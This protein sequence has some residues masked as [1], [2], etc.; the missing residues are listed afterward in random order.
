MTTSTITPS[1]PTSRFERFEIDNRNRAAHAG[2][3]LE[4]LAIPSVM[5]PDTSRLDPGATVPSF[6]FVTR[7]GGK[8]V[9]RD[10]A[11]DSSQWEPVDFPALAE[12]FL[13]TRTVEEDGRW[14][15][16]IGGVI[17]T[18]DAPT[19]RYLIRRAAEAGS[20]LGRALQLA[21]ALPAST[22]LVELPKALSAKF[23]APT[24]YDTED[25][26][27]WARAF[28]IAS[29]RSVSAARELAGTVYAGLGGTSGVGLPAK[30]PERMGQ[31]ARQ[32][33][34]QESALMRYAGAGSLS[35]DCGRF[36]SVVGIT[37][38]WEFLTQT[39]TLGRHHAMLDGTVF[40]LSRL[41][42]QRYRINGP[43]KVREGKNIVMLPLPGEHADTAARN[44]MSVDEISV[45]ASD[46]F[47]LRATLGRSRDIDNRFQESEEPVLFILAPFLPTYTG[48]AGVRWTTP[49]G[50]QDAPQSK[51]R[52]VPLHVSLAGAP[53][54]GDVAA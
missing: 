20:H 8:L 12:K 10:P 45:D 29:P 34:T 42:R 7:K 50:A 21:A 2:R 24:G 32:M 36:D 46:R 53:R 13:P 25:L 31:I 15:T 18:P 17:F 38:R 26:S 37:S 35:H 11:D 4:R 14:L 49:A 33:A 51:W 40:P 52:E 48:R 23:F 6:T 54:E 27:D 22:R 47:T 3:P 1:R 5:Y 41:G 43:F 19:T 44:S 30:K 39:D 28:G 9:D 16:S